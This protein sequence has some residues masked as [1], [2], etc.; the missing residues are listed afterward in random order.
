MFGNIFGSG[1]G[2]GMFGG[3]GILGL[4]LIL[5]VLGNGCGN[6]GSEGVLGTSRNDNNFGIGCGN[7]LPLI[8]I[9]CLLGNGCGGSDRTSPFS[10]GGC[11]CA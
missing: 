8:I 1:S 7:I 10:G 6:N 5:C 4:L 2:G 3:D 11:G 9:L